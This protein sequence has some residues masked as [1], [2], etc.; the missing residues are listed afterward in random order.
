M[1]FK[2]LY[3]L[4]ILSL[5]IGFTSGSCTRDGLCE[6][7]LVVENPIED[8]TMTVGDI[9]FLDLTNP[10]VFVCSEGG[11]VYDKS[12]LSGIGIIDVV[13]VQNPNENERLSMLKI[14]ALKEGEAI[15]VLSAYCDCLENQINF[16]VTSIV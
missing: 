14:T 15:I 6:G 11:I 9:L 2:T 1:S 7:T 13:E 3:P 4:L 12:N 16:N 5:A 8:I 10:P